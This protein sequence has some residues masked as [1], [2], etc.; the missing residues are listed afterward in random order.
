MKRS[1]SES[2]SQSII[3]VFVVDSQSNVKVLEIGAVQNRN[4]TKIFP[5]NKPSSNTLLKKDLSDAFQDSFNKILQAE[6]K[7]E[8]ESLNGRYISKN[9]GL[10]K[11]EKE[12]LT[13]LVKGYTKK[14]I[15]KELFVSYHTIGTHVKNIYQKLNVNNRANAIVKALNE[16][17]MH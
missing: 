7:S 14:E 15:S 17:L 9:Y 13:L 3:G 6:I 12:V 2:R 1:R 16:D 10:T 8:I 4:V 5:L 11:R